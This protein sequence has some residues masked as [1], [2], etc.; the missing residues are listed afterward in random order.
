MALSPAQRASYSHDHHSKIPFLT[1]PRHLSGPGDPR[2]VT[3]ALLASGW[4]VTSAPGDPRTALTGP[5]HA[6]HQLILDPLSTSYWQIESADWSWYASFGR[7]V[8]AEIVAGFTDRLIAGPRRSDVGIWERMATAGWSVERRPDG[9][10]ESRS[11]GPHRLRAE[12]VQLY[13][14]DPKRTAWRIEALP[15]YH[16]PPAW[17]MWISGAIPEHLLDGLAEQLVT[18]TPVIRGMHDPES[19]GA[20]QEPSGLTPEQAVAAHFTRVD[21]LSRRARNRRRTGPTAS[22]PA[23]AAPSAPASVS[24]R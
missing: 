13:E 22:L 17:R 16:G 5:D 6:R 10:G 15:K 19:H 23:P 7:M 4:S 2:H 9:T 3:H 14:E 8:P 24:L 12:L 1:T 11:S 18:T 20:Q 21:A